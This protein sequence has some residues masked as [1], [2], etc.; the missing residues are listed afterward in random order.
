MNDERAGTE[1]SADE[2]AQLA[3]R[4]AHQIRAYLKK[5]EAGGLAAV[6]VESVQGT[7]LDGELRTAVAGAIAALQDFLAKH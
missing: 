1:L 3:E 6:I 4:A 5:N 2:V 7:A